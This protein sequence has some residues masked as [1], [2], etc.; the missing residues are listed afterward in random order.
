MKNFV[1][2]IFVCISIFSVAQQPVSL[3]IGLTTDKTTS[4]LF[5][6]DIR[7]VDLGTHDVLAEQ[8]SEA[9]NFLLVKAGQ[10]GFKETNLTVVT[11]DGRLYS[12]TVV[13]DPNP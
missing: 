7:H 1:S 3:R 11:A 10:A 8:V 9:Q 4:L 5:P 13:Y 6:A 12:I 2:L